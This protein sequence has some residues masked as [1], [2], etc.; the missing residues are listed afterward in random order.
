M[1]TN[2]TTIILFKQTMK[3]SA[4]YTNCQTCPCM[5]CL[6]GSLINIPNAFTFVDKHD[7]P[8]QSV[9]YDASNED[10]VPLFK[11]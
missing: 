7:G 3:R 8:K 9:C 10:I 5:I 6:F 1:L 11:S 2:N 4:L